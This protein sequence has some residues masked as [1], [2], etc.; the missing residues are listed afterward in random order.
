MRWDWMIYTNKR[1]K[2]NVIII[3]INWGTDG[4]LYN[5][6]TYTYIRVDM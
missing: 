1:Q 6:S 3:I 5:Y 2:W 4:A